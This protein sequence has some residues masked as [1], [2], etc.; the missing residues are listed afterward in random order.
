MYLSEQYLMYRTAHL[1]VE[2]YQFEVLHLND[3]EGEIWLEK[4]ENRTSHIVRLLHK[5]FDW[6]NHLKKDIALVFQKTKAMTRYLQGKN[7]EIHNVYISSHAPVDDWESLKKPML[8]NEKNP[9]KMGVY[10]LEEK[11]AE[12]ERARLFKSL[13]I[14]IINDTE[15]FTDTEKEKQINNSKEKLMNALNLKQKEAE[16][17]FSFGK[18]FL[19]YLL[20]FINIALFIM[21]ETKA[22]GSQST[23]NLINFGAKYNP[24]IIDGEW[25]RIITSM[26]LHIGL[27]HLFMNMLAVYYLGITAERIYGSWRFLVIYLLAGIGGGLASFAFT[28]NVSAGASGAL[29]G[30]FGA[31]LYFGLLYKRIFSQTMGKGLLILIAINIVFGF[32][33]P[34]IDNG[35]HIGGL[36]TGFAASAIV[37]LPK[38]RRV[39]TQLGAFILYV[40]II[41]GLSLFGVQ[42]NINSANYQLIKIDEMLQQE[43]Y[44]EII[45]SATKGL[46]HPGELE[47]RLLFQRSYAYI[48][49]GKAELATKDLE[50]VVKLEDMPE[51]YYNLAILYSE[52]GDEQLA[53]E[54]AEKAYELKPND[55]DYI[56]FY[57]HITGEKLSN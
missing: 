24:A 37:G 33:F 26:F 14:P 18:P 40:L 9:I 57:E 28:F 44:E 1:L 5:G 45:N 39:A 30:L 16:T 15:N 49:L 35:A 34:Q 50:R 48:E 43:N 51:A 56:R 21:L 25:W 22:G 31:L 54:A 23:E 2:R 8:L 46:E 38:K 53:A 10:Y 6:K 4:F 32:S 3:N 12:N 47:G 20:L 27:I 42:N 36:I 13:D 52:R 29:F 19:T 11:E 41:G 55:E 17:V 7:I